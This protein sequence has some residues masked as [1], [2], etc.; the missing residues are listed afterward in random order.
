MNH[1]IGCKHTIALASVLAVIGLVAP[2]TAQDVSKE[3]REDAV[4]SEALEDASK[5]TE[6]LSERLDREREGDDSP[7]GPGASLEQFQDEE[8]QMT[9][10]EIEALKKK[11][12]SK[13]RAMIEKLDRI[14]EGDPHNPQ[15]PAWMFQKAELM[16]KL[17]NMEYLRVR[18]QYNQC[19]TAAE[20]GTTGDCEEPEP[21]Y[22]EPQAIYKEILTNHPD[23]DR[24]DEVI[25]RLGSGLI[26]A[27]QAGQ[28]VSYLQRLV[29]NYP[30]SVYLPDAHLALAEM[31]FEQELLGAAADNYKEVL[32]HP[33]NSNFD[34]ARYKLGWVYYNQG[35]YRK[36]VDTFKAV[37]ESTDE[38]LGFQEQAMNDL[39]VAYAEIDDGWLEVR[40]YFMKMRDEEFTYRKL[41]QMA[42]LYEGQGKDDLAIAIYEYFIEERPNHKRIPTWME[43]IIVAKK[44]VN[45]PEDLEATMNQYVA[46]LDPDGT[47]ARS[48]AEEEGALNN[49]AMLSQASLAYLAN[50]YHRQAQ[51]LDEREDYESAIK[52]YKEFIRRFPDATASFDMN[53]FVADIYLH[54]LEDFDQAAQY[55][56]KV[57]DLYKAGN[58]PDDAKQEDV[59]AIVKDSAYG[60]VSAYDELVKKHHEDSILVKMAEYQEQ[61]GDGEF[62]KDTVDATTESKPNPKVEMPEYESGFVKASD[63]YSELY[64]DDDITPTIDYVAAE[65]YKERGHYDKCIPRYENI[66]ENAPEHRY[67]SYSGGSLLVANYVLENWNEVEKWARYMM[68][69][70]I[71]H[72]TP[73]ED[74]R[75]AIALAINERAKELKEAEEFEEATS[76]LL[77]LAGEFPKSDLAPGALFNAGAIYEAGEQLNEALEVYQRVVDEYPDSLQ[78]P[79]AIYVMGLIYQTRADFSQAAEY[80]A[81]MG[82]TAD[83][84]DAEGEDREYK[85]HDN[86][87]DAV[88]RAAS[89]RAA[90]EEWP[91][92]IAAADKYVSLYADL[93]DEQEDI[94]KVTRQLAYLEMEREQWQEAIRRFETYLDRDDVER[95]EHVLV[96]AEI[97]LLI[98]KIKGR[99]WEERSNDHFDKA[100]EI[101]N[102]LDDQGQLRMRYYASQA[103]FR[104]AERIYNKFTEVTLSFPMSKLQKGLE[105][106]AEIHTEAEKLYREVIDM[107]SNEWLAASAY[108]IGQMYRDFANQLSDL[109]L[110]EG[111]TAE[112]ED[113]YRIELEMRIMPLEDQALDAFQYAQELALNNKAYNEWSSKSAKQ[114]SSMMEDAY[115]ITEQDG[116]GVEHGRINFFVPAPATDLEAIAERVKARKPAEPEPQPGQEQAPG[117]DTDP[118]E[119]PSP[120]AE[121]DG[122]Q[123]RR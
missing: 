95:D 25:F 29:Q 49:A 12:E 115:P 40:D 109:P 87:A 41:G 63:Q 116:V 113:Q 91:E 96:N 121:A 27:D 94:K 102:E 68:D 111:L 85:D 82:S 86:A 69:N 71:F 101:W 100:L 9:P 54:E 70:E 83:Y 48:N 90:M 36:S 21:D 39:V 46:Y 8:Q 44:K 67:A 61:H 13:N 99:N 65:V 81:K 22:S 53:F 104:Q 73:K 58:T 88:F 105:E 19:V 112:Q 50:T 92:A 20:Q 97:G 78:A 42:G 59:D 11:I 118:G 107:G 15:K 10:E 17:R 80:F 93:E 3:K 108:R 117:D 77:R 4:S 123:A 35:E 110:P 56:Q 75:Q 1:I 103:R 38:K 114:I 6:G 2:A 120:S 76:E 16:W 119:E 24:L 23:Y 7:K 51:R 74:L 32:K 60:V 34:F 45:D 43:S 37:V 98:E 79:E 31:F 62:R 106:K 33:D 66:I 26:E 89:L 18:A 52:Y 122:P 14:I 47:W 64:P 55:Y 30:N 84:T 5:R 72:V 57:V 28:A